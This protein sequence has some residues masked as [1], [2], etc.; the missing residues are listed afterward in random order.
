MRRAHQR[1]FE[2][3]EQAQARADALPR[4]RA[5]LERRRH[6][7]ATQIVDALVTYDVQRWWER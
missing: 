2:K 3:T 5:S 6:L 7:T 1:S 4:V